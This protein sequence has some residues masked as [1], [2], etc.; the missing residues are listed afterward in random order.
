MSKT[1]FFN[2]ILD[3]LNNGHFIKSSM[4]LAFRVIGV[5]SV[6]F[7]IIIIIRICN[8]G[9]S[10]YMPAKIVIGTIIFAITVAMAFLAIFQ[11]WFYRAD[12]IENITI[13][14]FVVVPV[15]SILLRAL[16]E[17]YLVFGLAVSLGGMFVIWLSGSPAGLF[18][19][20]GII[21]PGFVYSTGSEFLTGILFFLTINII[22]FSV[23]AL[24]YFLAETAI[25]LV[26]IANNTK[27]I[28]NQHFDA[29][30]THINN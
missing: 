24:F 27:I 3:A 16:G 15:I 30:E 19:M 5:L 1:F 26:A 28:S 29:I 13:T 8:V 22:A 17:I 2:K 12:T 25:V 21:V 4:A 11:I 7:G 6:L 14:D 18:P 20:P 10:E 23:L 9:F